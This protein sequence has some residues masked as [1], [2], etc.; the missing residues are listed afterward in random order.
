LN[1]HYCFPLNPADPVKAH[2][3]VRYDMMTAQ[4]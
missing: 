4:R 2:E 3:K 1:D